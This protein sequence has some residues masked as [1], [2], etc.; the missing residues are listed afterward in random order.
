MAVKAYS[1]MEEELGKMKLDEAKAEIVSAIYF[2]D[3]SDYLR[4]L[5]YV[6]KRLDQDLCKLAEENPHRAWIDTHP[7]AEDEEDVDI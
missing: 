7:G 3:S 4:T 1:W 5:W 6:L 2:A